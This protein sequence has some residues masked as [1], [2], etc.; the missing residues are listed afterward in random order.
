MEM[1][2]LGRANI[3]T[4]AGCV[5]LLVGLAQFQYRFDLLELSLIARFDLL[6]FRLMARS[7][8]FDLLLFTVVARKLVVQ[9]ISTG[10]GPP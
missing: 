10:I 8:V 5:T 1:T 9:P 2:N 7:L 6:E 3:K 4:S